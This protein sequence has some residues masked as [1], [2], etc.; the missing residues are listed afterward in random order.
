MIP[1][2]RARSEH[3]ATAERGSVLPLTMGAIA[4]A[5]ALIATIAVMSAVYLDRKQLLALADAVAADAA[6][7]IDSDAYLEGSVTLTDDGVRVAAENYL[8]AAPPGIVTLPGTTVGSPTGSPDAATAEVTLVALSR[9]GFL[10]WA[11]A[12]WSDGIAIS[13]TATARGG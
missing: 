13:V 5:A 7:R 2:D 1:A 3:G 8:A 10:P 12:P 11:L 4:V 6:T 9:P